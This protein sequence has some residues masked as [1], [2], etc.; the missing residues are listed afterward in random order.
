MAHVRCPSCGQRLTVPY[1]PGDVPLRCP[2]CRAKFVH[3]PSSTRIPASATAP[4]SPSK[5]LM[6]WALAGIACAALAAISSTTWLLVNR[7]PS[8]VSENALTLPAGLSS[9]EP[10]EEVVITA[11]DEPSGEALEAAVE[12]DTLATATDAPAA[13]EDQRS[14]GLSPEEL[15]QRA[16]PAVVR[17][18]VMDRN[19]N[20]IGFGSGFFVSPDGLLVTNYHVIEQAESAEVWLSNNARFDV[21]GIAAL[22]TEY[23][24]AL[25][26]VA[27]TDLPFLRLSAAEPPAVGTRVFAIGNPHGLTSTLSNGLISAL[28]RDA[29]TV[30]LLQTNAAISPGSSG[31][32]LLTENGSVVGVTTA[33]LAGGQN[34]NFAVTASRVLE[35]ISTQHELLALGS[36]RTPQSRTV[37]QRRAPEQLPA[38]TLTLHEAASS[39]DLLEIEANLYRDDMDVNIDVRDEHGRTPLSYAA[40]QGFPKAI[41]L[42]LEAGADVNARDYV[43]SA[44]LHWA[45]TGQVAQL[46]I[47]GGATVDVTDDDGF[48]PLYWAA[49]AN[50]RSTVEALVAHGANVNVQSNDG[51]TPLVRAA[52]EGLLSTVNIL[53]SAGADPNAGHP[54]NGLTPLWLAVTRDHVSIVKVLLE[55]GADANVMDKAGATPLHKATEAGRS[56]MLM[57]GL[58]LDAGAEMNT[59]TKAGLAPLHIAAANGRYAA[60]KLLLDRGADVN[61]RTHV[62]FTPL[63]LAHDSV[64]DLLRL[65]G[66]TE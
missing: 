20:P 58:L 18:L 12:Q 59:R 37:G 19:S 53:L 61:V 43:G 52:H 4:H 25:L 64:A 47:A 41:S 21:D 8:E 50:R 13:S 48:T 33:Y 10:T 36:A 45:D 28:R 63:A 42:L 14:I 40:A 16:A 6:V 27:G 62:G 15:F 7:W 31:G 54:E 49:I 17:L 44:P 65:H 46:L 60:V 30:V 2:K 1:H 55:A 26:R 11:P 24:L 34:L 3:Q 32:P 5:R 39:G 9:S 38:P 51:F 57:M 22:D 29:E 35:L 23:D 56:S 66:G